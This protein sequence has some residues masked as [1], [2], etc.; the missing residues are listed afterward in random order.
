MLGIVLGWGLECWVDGS[1]LREECDRRLGRSFSRLQQSRGYTKPV[2]CKAR[3][4]TCLGSVVGAGWE[5]GEPAMG[6]ASQKVDVVKAFA[7][8]WL[9]SEWRGCTRLHIVRH[10]AGGERQDKP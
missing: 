2:E 5:T 10:F 3:K 9:H 7:D 4:A 8:L 6:I 1:G